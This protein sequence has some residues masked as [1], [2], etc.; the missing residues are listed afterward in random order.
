MLG[1]DKEGS[2]DKHATQQ[3][4]DAGRE[5][6]MG[7]SILYPWYKRAHPKTDAQFKEFCT[8][9]SKDCLKEQISKVFPGNL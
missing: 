6:Q 2:C 5:G 9:G 4:E 8:S 1:I 7:F 3:V